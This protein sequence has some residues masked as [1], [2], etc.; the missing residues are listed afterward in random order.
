[1]RVKSFVINVSLDHGVFWA[2]RFNGEIDGAIHIQTALATYNL[3]NGM[4]TEMIVYA[5]F[6]DK[7]QP[8][9]NKEGANLQTNNNARVGINCRT[10]NSPGALA[11]GSRCLECVNFSQWQLTSPVA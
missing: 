8:P 10:C 6:P 9:K 5:F 4:P 7:E 2:D 3:R 11:I 1:M